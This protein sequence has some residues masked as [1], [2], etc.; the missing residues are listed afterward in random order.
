MYTIL[1]TDNHE[2]ITTQRERIMHRSKL[3]NK[4][5]FLVPPNYDDLNMDE[6]TVCM[7]YKRPDGELVSD[8][9]TASD[10]LYKE[11][12]EYIVPFD[13]EL[14]RFPGE[15]E[16]KLTFTYVDMDPD[17]NIVQRVRKTD[18]AIINIIPTSNWDVSIA[19]PYL[20]SLDKMMVQTNIL[21]NK[22]LD[23]NMSLSDAMPEDLIIKDGR[24][25]LS[26][27][28]DAIE[29]TVGIPLEDCE[30]E[31]GVPVIDFSS[32][33]PGNENNPEEDDEFDN[34]VEF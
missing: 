22:A 33:N 19:D 32:A 11:H 25:Y 15:V 16:V 26:R 13:T 28:G 1:L 4:M 29:N 6:C 27:N 20:T 17:G 9:L 2:L 18:C 8:L 21:L 34:V 3:V 30:C 7:E 24:A 14:T 5:H 31:N 12:L 10:T 23:I